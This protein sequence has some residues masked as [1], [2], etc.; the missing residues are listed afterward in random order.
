MKKNT[1]LL[2]MVILVIAVVLGVLIGRYSRSFATSANK[3]EKIQKKPLYWIDPMEPRIRYQ[4]PGKSRMGMELTPVYPDR[5]QTTNTEGTVR[6]SPIVENNLGIRTAPVIIGA[7]S[8]QIETVGYVEPNENNISHIHTY[9]DG[10]VKKLLV[11]TIGEPVKK[12][13]LLFQLYSPLLLTSQEEY[14][15]ALESKNKNL[16]SASYKRLL[17]LRISEPQILQL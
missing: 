10:W 17:A 7:L 9:A 5:E 8:R 15:I 3:V 16:L 14:L 4:G 6:I 2:L 13:Q 11:K 12:D 1:T